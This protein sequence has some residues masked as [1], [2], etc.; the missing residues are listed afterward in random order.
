M[1]PPSAIGPKF[2]VEKSDLVDSFALK[3]AVGKNREP[4]LVLWVIHVLSPGAGDY[5]PTCICTC[6]Y[7]MWLYRIPYE[8]NHED[9]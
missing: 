1:D 7:L 8:R 6:T 4:A 9:F 3:L 5:V 2:L